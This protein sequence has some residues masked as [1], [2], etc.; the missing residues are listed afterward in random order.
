[1]KILVL[2]LAI[3]AFVTASPVAVDSTKPTYS[4]LCSK[5][6]DCNLPEQC[7]MV[8]GQVYAGVCVNTTG[9]QYCG[10]DLSCPD[11]Y[12]CSFKVGG[13]SGRH[14]RPMMAC[15]AYCIPLVIV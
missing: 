6:S 4:G 14:K 9:L 8:P 5:R 12:F 10:D 3:I 7:I 11:E 13:C 15:P 2:V 1:M